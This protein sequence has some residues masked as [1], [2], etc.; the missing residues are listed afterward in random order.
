MVLGVPILGWLK[1]DKM[2]TLAVILGVPILNWLKRDN[3][4]T[5]AVNEKGCF[6]AYLS[7]LSL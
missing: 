3:L 5:L 7:S 4:L 6:T 2:L 1:R